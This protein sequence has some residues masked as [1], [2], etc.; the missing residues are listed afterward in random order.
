MNRPTVTVLTLIVGLA[1]AAMLAC[2]ALAQNGFGEIPRG[3][4]NMATGP[5]VGEHIPDF[6]AL[7][8]DGVRRTFDDIKGPN[9]ALVFFFRSA[10]W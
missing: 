10:D 7:D 4:E 1:G 8:Q 5:E 6:A 3:D 2:P 9:G